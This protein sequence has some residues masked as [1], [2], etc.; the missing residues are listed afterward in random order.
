M[1]TVQTQNKNTNAF[2]A[3]AAISFGLA[4][5]A[6]IVGIIFLPVNG[7]VRGFLGLGVLY[8]V[9]SAFTLAK[10]IRDRQQE[11]E[12]VNRVDQARLDNYLAQHDPLH[13]NA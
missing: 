12:L 8:T 4:L 6:V 10:C 5:L 9:T 1:S 2:Y 13:T 3:Q 11:S 7:W